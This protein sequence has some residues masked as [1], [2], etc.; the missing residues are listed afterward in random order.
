M[1][2]F[3]ALCDKVMALVRKDIHVPLQRATT[4]LSGA[5][6]TPLTS[7]Q[8]RGQAARGSQCQRG[9]DSDSSERQ[10]QTLSWHN[11][12]IPLTRQTSGNLDLSWPKLLN[13]F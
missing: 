7:G 3:G 10:R 1:Y 8:G 4:L 5:S 9:R 2:T 11:T 12:L 6:L 13:T